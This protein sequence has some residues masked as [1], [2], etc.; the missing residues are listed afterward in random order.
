[1]HPGYFPVFFWSLA[2]L[3][4]F[5][6]YGELLR[7]RINRPEFADIGWGLTCAWGMAVVL[8]IS[9]F[10]MATHQAKAPALALLILGGALASGYFLSERFTT[11]KGKTHNKKIKQASKPPLPTCN[12]PLLV[13]GSLPWLLA[14]LH[15][16]SSIAWPHQIDPNDDLV[17]YLMLPK[18]ILDTGTLL[19]PFNF[20]R[21]G[22]YGGHHLLQALVMIVGGER[23]GHIPDIGWAR[24][25]IVAITYNLLR[26]R[27]GHLSLVSIIILTVLLFLPAPRISTASSMS[28]AALLLA[29][30]QTTRIAIKSQ[31]SMSTRWVT[32]VPIALLLA[33]AGTMRPMA[34]IA[35]CFFLLFVACR[36]AIALDWG[37]WRLATIAGTA[38]ALLLLPWMITLWCSNETLI[39]PPFLG[40]VN[41]LFVDMSTRQGMLA[42]IA[43]AAHF[44]LNPYVWPLVLSLFPLL[45]VKSLK[46]GFEVF[47]A[48]IVSVFLVAESCAVVI[49]SEVYRYTFPLLYAATCFSLG[50]LASFTASTLSFP[51][52]AVLGVIIAL[53]FPN[54]STG[55]VLLREMAFGLRAQIK[56]TQGFF[57]PGMRDSLL[58]L[59]NAVPQG[60]RILSVVDAP[61]YF[62]FKR[63]RI[64]TINSIGGAG[65]GGGIPVEKGPSALK[66][67]FLR[68]GYRYV[69]AVDFH[70]AVL[71]YNRQH[72]LH[73]TRPEWYWNEVW[74][75]YAL[76]FMRNVESISDWGCIEKR[77]ANM[78]LL[79]LKSDSIEK[80]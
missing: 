53:L 71:L 52:L 22:S 67:Y 12:W 2:V 6:G 25:V 30:F 79:D 33:A 80:P 28:G 59:Q 35:G 18:K 34:L 23:N 78:V 19:E 27:K 5:W 41:P 11:P 44:F 31:P 24:P 54:I 48:V 21:A 75:R 8:A 72:W 47:I 16:A 42:D 43:Q 29:L 63:N 61:Y 13:F 40:N 36:H 45:F 73:H 65:P 49:P 46:V 7:R 37:R 17:C 62:D 4:S 1:M 15:F 77:S 60:E 70:S 38:A 26:E 50:G 69:I 9:G 10:L 56:P 58:S 55:V 20:Q 51:S 68:L 66:E 14:T 3:A 64:D 57:Q 76:D 39:N 74:G 32:A